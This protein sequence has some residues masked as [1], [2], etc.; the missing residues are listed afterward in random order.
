MKPQRNR[1]T[2]RVRQLE[3]IVGRRGTLHRLNIR[4]NQLNNLVFFQNILDDS[5]LKYYLKRRVQVGDQ[6]MTLAIAVRLH[7]VNALNESVKRL[8]KFRVESRFFRA[9]RLGRACQN[10]ASDSIELVAPAFSQLEEASKTYR[11]LLYFSHFQ[12]SLESKT[13][14]SSQ[15]K[16]GS[17]VV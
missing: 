14:M 6:Y 12:K 15:M 2:V 10:P 1:Y 8:E 4:R 5:F 11:C 3:L 16:K 13:R 7:A 17:T 9:S